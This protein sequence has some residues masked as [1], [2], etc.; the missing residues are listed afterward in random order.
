MLV[1]VDDHRIEFRVDQDAGELLYV[2]DLIGPDR[3]ERFF[4]DEQ[5]ETVRHYRDGKLS[6][7]VGRNA[8]GS[9]AAV[10]IVGAGF[11]LAKRSD[12]IRS[13]SE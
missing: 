1:D 4:T 12:L 5:W 13:D 6:S 11:V 3:Q 9:M 2:D 8:M 10:L 7:W